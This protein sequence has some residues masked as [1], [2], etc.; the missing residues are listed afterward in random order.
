M[1]ANDRVKIGGAGLFV[2]LHRARECIG[3]H[4]SDGGDLPLECGVDDAIEGQGG[5]EDGMRG[6]GEERGIEG[7]GDQCKSLQYLGQC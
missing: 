6:V 5:V 4:E 2:E 7:H 3:I 1:S